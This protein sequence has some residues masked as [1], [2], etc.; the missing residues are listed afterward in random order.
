MSPTNRVKWQI[1]RHLTVAAIDAMTHIAGGAQEIEL[2]LTG[3]GTSADPLAAAKLQSALCQLQRNSVRCYLAVPPN[4]LHEERADRA[5]AAPGHS[6]A[7]VTPAEKTLAS[8]IEGLILGQLCELIPT[9]SLNTERLRTLQLQELRLRKFLYGRGKSQSIAVP[10]RMDITDKTSTRERVNRVDTRVADLFTHIDKVGVD[11]ADRW[12]FGLISN[13][14]FEATE[15]TY[16][17]GRYDL[18]GSLVPSV[19]LLTVTRHNVKQIQARTDEHS[20]GHHTRSLA[21]YLKRLERYYEIQRRELP[22]SKFVEVT[23]ADGGVGIAA[24]MAGTLSIHRETD[25]GSELKFLQAGLEPGG[26]SRSPDAIGAGQGTKKILRQCHR[27]RGM[28]T[29]AT[30]RV[31]I[32][33]TFLNDD[34]HPGHHEFENTQDSAFDVEP[35]M[36]QCRLAAGT[37]WTLLFPVDDEIAPLS[38]FGNVTT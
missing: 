6:V 9:K 30:G 33:R 5:F 22:V 14:A 32:S 10:T 25:L 12:W 8:S 34:G 18:S 26:T 31:E 13:F 15:N 38:P 20:T 36:Q 4:T 35:F 16:R 17:Y 21:V 7:A 3:S 2:Q 23:V 29:L 27:L 1:P 28:F 24:K 19:R 11:I 37:T